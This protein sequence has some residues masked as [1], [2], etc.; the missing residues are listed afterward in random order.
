MLSSSHSTY[1]SYTYA[2]I[3]DQL[4]THRDHA[5]SRHVY[6]SCQDKDSNPGLA[7]SE[8][9]TL[10]HL[11]HYHAFDSISSYFICFH[12]HMTRYQLC[13]III[14]K[15][16]SKKV[17]LLWL[18]RFPLGW[19]CKITNIIIWIHNW[20][21]IY[22]ISK[23]YHGIGGSTLWSTGQPLWKSAKIGLGRFWTTNI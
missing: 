7:G 21:V 22:C 18:R 4:G 20:K 10:H 11:T 23:N 17:T 12:W 15:N 16:N 9:T 5:C 6:S 14:N 13:I 8:N 19:N 1:S 2:M 3:D